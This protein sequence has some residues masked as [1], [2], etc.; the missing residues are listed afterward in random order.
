MTHEALQ[1]EV[2]MMLLMRANCT[3]MASDDLSSYTTMMASILEVKTI[4]AG[5]E[6][7]VIDRSGWNCSLESNPSQL[8]IQKWIFAWLFARSNYTKFI[9]TLNNP[10]ESFEDRF[11]KSYGLVYDKNE[12]KKMKKN[13]LKMN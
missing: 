8:Q 11:M 7:P 13:P 3:R 6:S 4:V 5:C 2:S 1:L 10:D 12:V 9:S